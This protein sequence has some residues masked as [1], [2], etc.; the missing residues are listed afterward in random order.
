MLCTTLHEVGDDDY[1]DT[2]WWAF[3]ATATNYFVVQTPSTSCI[4]FLIL[5]YAHISL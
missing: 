4:Q 2:K 5:S 3:G 1:G